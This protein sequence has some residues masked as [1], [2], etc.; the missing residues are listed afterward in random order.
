LPNLDADPEPDTKPEHQGGFRR[1][2]NS[3]VG[4]FDS[5]AKIAGAIVVFLGL[6]TAVVGFL[7]NKESDDKPSPEPVAKVIDKSEIQA[8]AS[9]TLSRQGDNDYGADNTLDGS[10]KTAWVE[11]GPQRLGIG[12]HLTYRFPEATRL[13][14]VRLVNGYAKSPAAALD[15]GA[16]RTVEFRTETHRIRRTLAR[17]SRMQTIKA[18]FGR[19]RNLTLTLL[20]AFDGDM[21]PDVALSEVWFF[22]KGK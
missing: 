7:H 9:S 13:E 20:S 8:S 4:F 2:L 10:R 11:G 12:E 15:N 16:L 1:A 5:L 17:D 21:F 19:T 3:V 14:R 6:V 18:N 22:A